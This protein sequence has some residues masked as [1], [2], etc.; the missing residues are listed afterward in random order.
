MLIPLEVSCAGANLWT[1]KFRTGRE[2]NACLRPLRARISSHHSSSFTL[3]LRH[4]PAMLS[5][6]SNP[7]RLRNILCTTL[8]DKLPMD[9]AHANI[10]AKQILKYSS[11]KVV[12]QAYNGRISFEL[13]RLN[14]ETRKKED[15]GQQ[16]SRVTCGNFHNHIRHLPSMPPPMQKH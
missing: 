12:S 13:P 11:K 15:E 10:A 8:C 6:T 9:L 16:T 3:T 5:E 7:V 1:N 2:N 14:P 4:S